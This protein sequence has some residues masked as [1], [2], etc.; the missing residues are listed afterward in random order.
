MKI[1]V[2]TSVLI[3]VIADEP[4]KPVLVNMARGANLIAP[5][6]IH[7]EIGNAL[8]AMF[9]RKLITLSKAQQAITIYQTIPLQLVDVDLTRSVNIAH[10]L[11][12]YAYDAYLIQCAAQY[13]APLMT[14][15]RNLRKS[16]KQLKIDVIEVKL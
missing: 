15:D 1:V 2:D 4:E 7:W 14:L 11:N 10:Q 3:A 5:H 13:T 6:S 12:I 16:A 8:S 9:K